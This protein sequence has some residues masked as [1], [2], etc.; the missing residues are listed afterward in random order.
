MPSAT[1]LAALVSD[2]LGVDDVDPADRLFD[3]GMSSLTVV[4]LLSRIRDEFEVELDMIEAFEAGTVAELATL[5]DSADT[6]ADALP[7]LVPVSPDEHVLTWFQERFWYDMKNVGYLS[8]H[9]NRAFR[10]TGDLDVDALRWTFDEIVR[11]QRNLRSRFPAK[12][13]RPEIVVEDHPVTLDVREL[14]GE[15]L[16]DFVRA[17]MIEPFDI[18]N[19]PLYRFALVTKAPGSHLLLMN[20]HEIVSDGWSLDVLTR[21]VNALYTARVTGA[22]PPPELAIQY[23]DFAA[24]QRRAG[25]VNREALLAFW[26]RELERA[27]LTLALPLDG[28]GVPSPVKGKQTA[29]LHIDLG[30]E[31]AQEV[32]DLCDQRSMSPF[33]VY[34][35]A[36]AVLLRRYTGVDDVVINSPVANRNRSELEPIVGLFAAGNLPFRIDLSGNGTF[37]DLLDRV[38][39]TARAAFAHAEVPVEIVGAA[40]ARGLPVGIVRQVSPRFRYRVPDQE[41]VL[42]GVECEMFQAIGVQ[43]HLALWID[44][45]HRDGV[46][47]TIAFDTNQFEPAMMRRMVVHA[48]RTLVSAVRNPDLPLSR[49]PVLLAE[50]Q[51]PVSAPAVEAAPTTLTDL[52]ATAAARV[53]GAVAVR[54]ADGAVT[55]AELADRAGAVAARLRADGVAPGTRVPLDLTPSVATVVAVLGAWLAGG[56]VTTGGDATSEPAAD[57]PDGVAFALPERVTHRAVADN[58]RWQ[59]DRYAL[60]PGDVV[61][62]LPGD[63][64]A[65]WVLS[66]WP[67]LVAGATVVVPEATGRAAAG[68]LYASDVTVASVPVPVA[69]ALTEDPPAGLRLLAIWGAWP[70][71]GELPVGERPRVVAHHLVAECGGVAAYADSGAETLKPVLRPAP[72]VALAVLDRDG[73]AVPP[74]AAGELCV[75][76]TPE[77]VRTGDLARVTEDRQV[78]YLGRIEDELVLRGYRLTEVAACIEVVLAAH[79]AVAEAVVATVGVPPSLTAY[80]RFEPGASV[81][82]DQLAEWLAAQELAFGPTDWVA[83]DE[84]RARPDGSVIRREYATSEA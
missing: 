59:A 68:W 56:V 36:Y 10:V 67:A 45:R 14:S 84:L 43:E 62:H 77:P 83:V 73:N 63:G 13:G 27:P 80:V 42:P 21:D 69:T 33:M 18:D 40:L 71:G 58:A 41:L 64:A 49:L 4:Q 34:L 15:A 11:R 1:V 25:S 78:A 81:P 61:T 20:V 32:R 31:F 66:V 35:A 70:T 65:A 74:G 57:E 39:E 54:A 52:V 38:R 26:E 47:L 72:G 16:E 8:A 5:V 79:P 29:A 30:A 17:L 55:Y 22:P 3:L 37:G 6:H 19:G 75:V 51:V 50:E 46:R 9:V 2:V 12:D 23:G 7:P 60:E 76:S 53:P 48:D 28:G 44:D 82:F 24:W